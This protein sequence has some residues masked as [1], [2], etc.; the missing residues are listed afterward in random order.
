MVLKRKKIQDSPVGNT[1]RRKGYRSR[2]SINLKTKDKRMSNRDLERAQDLYPELENFRNYY[3]D[4]I[5]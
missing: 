4:L 1:S 2:S 3:K 5:K